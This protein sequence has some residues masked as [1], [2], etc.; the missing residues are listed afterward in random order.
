MIEL[1]VRLDRAAARSYEFIRA[2]KLAAAR[3]GPPDLNFKL[4]FNL[5]TDSERVV[6]VE[7]I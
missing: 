7:P 4:K 1:R 3:R 6:Q 5:K 2:D